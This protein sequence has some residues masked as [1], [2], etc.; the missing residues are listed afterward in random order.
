[1][2]PQRRELR[3]RLGRG[4]GLAHDDLP[5]VLRRRRDLF[6]LRDGADAG[7]PP[8]RPLQARGLHHEPAPPEHGQGHARDR[9]HRRLRLRHG[10]LHGLVQRQ[11]VRRL[12][13][14][15]PD[16]RAVHV[17]VLV[18]DRLQHPRPSAPLAEAG[19]QLGADPLRHR[20]RR[21]HRHVARALHH[22]RDEAAPRLPAVVLGD[23]LGDG[24]G[25]GDL[26]RHDRPV[27]RP[28]APLHPVPARDL[29]L[30]DARDPPRGEETDG[31]DGG[32]RAVKEPRLYGIMAEFPTPNDLIAAAEKAREAGYRRMDAYTPYPIE[33]VWEAIGHHR[34]RVPLLVLIGGL[35]GCAGGYLLQYWVSAIEYPLDVG[36]RPYN[37]WPAFIPVTFQTTILVARRLAV[38]RMLAV[39]RAPPP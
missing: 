24:L 37:S 12:H 11:C 3:L 28:H 33:Q 22:H 15:E 16:A 29:H 10:D 35:I 2:R 23:V 4:A 31:G 19:P 30:R 20:D 18:A 17:P 25:Q 21:E 14:Q 6:R 13:D 9:A 1:L 34:S 39:H 7:D 32:G 8:A 38:G 5:A 36:G 27:R 26:P